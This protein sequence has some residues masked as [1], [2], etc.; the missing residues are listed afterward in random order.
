MTKWPKRPIPLFADAKRAIFDPTYLAMK[1]ESD[2]SKDLVATSAVNFYE[3]VTSAE[4]DEYYSK[5]RKPNDRSPLEY[6][7]NSKLMKENGQLVEKKW[8]VGGMYSAAIEQV[9]MWLQKAESVA[10]TPKQAA[11][12]RSLIEYYKTGDL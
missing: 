11:A 3:G 1:V 5:L 12:L 2:V 6:G 9:V 4:V 10:E 7:L 8:M